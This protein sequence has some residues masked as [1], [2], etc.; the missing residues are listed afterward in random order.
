M[1]VQDYDE[2]M[3]FNYHYLT[4]GGQLWWWEDDIQPYV[5]NWNVYQCPSRSPHLGYTYQRPVGAPNPLV[6]DYKAPAIGDWPVAPWAG[7]VSPMLSCG[8]GGGCAPRNMAAIEDVSGTIMITDSRSLE[9]WS[10]A[11]VDAC[12][13]GGQTGCQ[14]PPFNEK[15]HND[16][17]N[18]A[19]VDGHVKFVKNSR[20]GDWTTRAGD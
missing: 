3:P 14:D 9:I 16:G 4:G 8:T 19:F 2:N 20:P 11:Q 13:A 18:A 1:Y 10:S 15:R 7:G 17:F 5:K 12:A 6:S